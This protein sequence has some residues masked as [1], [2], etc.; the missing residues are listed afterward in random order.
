MF[1]GSTERDQWQ[2]MRYE[3]P[4]SSAVY[5]HP[6]Q[7][8]SL[9]WSSATW[10]WIVIRYPCLLKACSKILFISEWALSYFVRRLSFQTCGCVIYCLKNALY[11]YW[12]WSTSSIVCPFNYYSHE[13][14]AYELTYLWEGNFW[15]LV[16]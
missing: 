15:R 4:R 1:S 8:R 6:K 2:E 11:V 16:W 13:T 14:S 10:C 12:I 3:S 5:F 7:L 9:C